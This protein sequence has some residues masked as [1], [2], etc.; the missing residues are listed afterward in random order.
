MRPGQTVEGIKKMAVVIT[1]AQ[2]SKWAKLDNLP[3]VRQPNRASRAREHLTPDEVE[4]MIIAARQ[5]GGRLAERDALLIMIAYRHGL[6][7]RS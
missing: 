2:T 7:H 3:P 1:L 4:R 5:A 6:R